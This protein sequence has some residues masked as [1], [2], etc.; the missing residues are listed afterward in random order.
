VRRALVVLFVVVT[1]LKV[2]LASR[3]QLFGDEAFYWAC[4]RRLDLAYSDHPFMTALLVR[5]GTALL[6]DTTLGVRL[7][8]LLC[9]ALLVPVIY[10]LGRRVGDERD[11]ALAAILLLALPLAG[12][13][14]F[15]AV[16]DGPL[17]LLTGL[18]VLLVERAVR[19]GS[20]AAWIGA[21]LCAGLALST[22]YRGALLLA[23]AGALLFLTRAGRAHLRT[24]GPWLALPIA[25]AGLLPVLVFNARLDWEPLRFQAAERHAV[26]RGPMAWLRYPVEQGLVVTPLLFVAL[27]VALWLAVRRARRGDAR[28]A[29]LACFALLPI[30]AFFLVSPITDSRHDYVHWPEPGYLPLLPLV[31]AVLAGWARQ[32][33]AGRVLAVATPALAVGI[34]VGALLDGAAGGATLR[35]ARQ[36]LG[37]SELAA[38]TR[39]RLAQASPAGRD[40]DGGEARRPL[41]VADNY[42]AAAE[43]QFLLRDGA[44]VYVLNHRLNAEHGRALQYRLWQRD[45][46]GLHGR[47]GEPALVVVETSENGGPRRAPWLAHVRSLFDPLEPRGVLPRAGGVRDFAFFEGRVAAR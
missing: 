26:P 8:F 17:L 13:A 22:H 31:P 19:T 45:E 34:T 42:R 12:G 20:T 41:L 40:G 43:L 7:L 25:L 24:P 39:E 35:L 6:G 33:R 2:I 14:T 18:A 28:A 46:D 1:A 37:W 29:V 16:P 44:D 3:L 10:A 21:G 30:G 9:G 11:A 32:G 5:G 4:S 27:L 36:F 38:A 15:L 47:A 23:S